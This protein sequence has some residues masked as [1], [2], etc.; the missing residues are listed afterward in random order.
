M[1]AQAEKAQLINKLE[2]ALSVLQHYEQRFNAEI[3]PL[4]QEVDEKR[5]KLE[6]VQAKGGSWHGGLKVSLAAAR[7]GSMASIIHLVFVGAM[8]L[9]ILMILFFLSLAGARGA[10]IVLYALIALGFMA[11]T[12]HHK[13]VAKR[14]EGEVYDWQAFA[15]GRYNNVRNY[16]LENQTLIGWIDQRYQSTQAVQYIVQCLRSG[17]ADNYK[18]ALNLYEQQL[19]MWQMEQGQRE[20]LQIAH[21]THQAASFAAFAS[22]VNLFFSR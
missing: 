12:K 7:Q 17:R 18:E 3:K 11:Y 16:L 14:I 9:F 1:S 2:V 22:A 21:L 20:Q 15:D 10:M 13:R 8:V 6:E 19:H 5:M 4:L